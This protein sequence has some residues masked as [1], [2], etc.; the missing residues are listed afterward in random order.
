MNLVDTFGDPVEIGATGSVTLRFTPDGLARADAAIGPD[1]PDPAD[2][3]ATA[4]TFEDVVPTIYEIVI[5]VPGY[6][7]V[8]KTVNVLP[9]DAA[10][11]TL[12]TTSVLVQD[13]D[14]NENIEL[15]GEASQIVGSVKVGYGGGSP[16]L[17]GDL[18][19]GR[20][21]TLTV[22][23]NNKDLSDRFTL[24]QNQDTFRG[25]LSPGTYTFTAT[26]TDYNDGTATVTVKAGTPPPG[27]TLVLTPLPRNVVVP[28]A[29]IDKSALEEMN[30]TV[31]GL[32]PHPTNT[33]GTAGVNPATV[34]ARADAVSAATFTNVVPGTYRLTI[35]VPNSA[36]NT[37][38]SGYRDSTT[39]EDA[40]AFP[41][42]GGEETLTIHVPANSVDDYSAPLVRMAVYKRID[43]FSGEGPAGRAIKKSEAL[44][45]GGQTV[46]EP[47]GA[48]A[49]AATYFEFTSTTRDSNQDRRSLTFNAS[50]H[51]SVTI[52]IVAD[53]TTP[54][55]QTV[56]LAKSE[57][58]GND[59]PDGDAG[60]A[61]DVA[62][63]PADDCTGI[64]GVL[65]G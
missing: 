60:T 13:L 30:D 15:E 18:S 41:P 42:Q 39:A 19:P 5:A 28:L 58:P 45:T 29:G 38:L 10:D 35:D 32:T 16:P 31:L 12:A 49:D 4:V 36:P 20:D 43:L 62:T 50:G 63:I 27:P 3:E 37:R 24:D 2:P 22:T 8:T 64:P 56:C 40:T 33:P 7:T 53:G 23:R 57:I 47:Q 55:T 6:A 11:V 54:A 61:D 48:D 25:D 14:P 52:T 21:F 44:A 46:L 17:L 1:L 59:G 34:V 51:D 26:A 9:T 65:T